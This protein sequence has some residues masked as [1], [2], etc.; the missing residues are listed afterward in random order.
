MFV[1]RILWLC[2]SAFTNEKQKT[3]GSWLQPLAE[4]LQNSGRCEI[5]NVTLGINTDII[6][7]EC[8][9]IKQWILPNTKPSH[10]GQVPSKK[11]CRDVA[12]I[13]R[14]IDP[15]IVHVWGTE[16]LW[17]YIYKSGYIS[18]PNTIIDI[19]G[20]LS[21]C[22]RSY[23]GGLSFSERIKSVHLKE[24]IMP[25]RMLY[26]KKRIFKERG[27]VELSCLK[28]FNNISVQSGWVENHIRLIHPDARIHKTK[29]CLRNAFYE[30]T[31]WLYKVPSGSPMIFSF[32]SAA[33]PYKGIHVLLKALCVLKR[34]YPD[35]RL[36]LGGLIDVGVRLL[37]GYS[38]FLHD[39]IKENGL[40]DN[41]TYLGP[42]SDVGIIEQLQKCNVCVIPSFIESYCLVLAESMI[43]G[44]PTVTSYTGAM[45]EFADNRKET[46]FYNPVD[47]VSCAAFVDELIQNQSLAETISRNARERRLAENHPEDVVNRQLDIYH[48]ILY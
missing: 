19:Q 27:K 9:G 28:K 42:L 40:Q 17:A 29:I 33:V 31:P 26:I 25:W 3:T 10:Y 24:I 15:D 44:V 23:Y 2:N 4:S 35:I 46:M 36:C 11:T 30:A 37:D 13:E 43:T 5:F 48:S 18:C 32:C 38:V 41:V 12:G 1:M 7:N 8:N 16:S 6:E 21:E 20:L 39:L 34:K 47:Y 22:Y 14:K 45:P